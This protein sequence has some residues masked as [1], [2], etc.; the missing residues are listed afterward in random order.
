MRFDPREETGGVSRSLVSAQVGISVKKK[1]SVFIGR[2]GPSSLRGPKVLDFYAGFCAH[3][4]TC[5]KVD[6]KDI[7]VLNLILSDS[8]DGASEM[9][10]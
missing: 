8:S 3:R 1:H 2:L 10:H 6:G 9:S 5:L 7:K 4:A